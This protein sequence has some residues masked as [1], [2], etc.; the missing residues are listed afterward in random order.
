MNQT[1]YFLKVETILTYTLLALVLCPKMAFAQAKN[2]PQK[3]QPNSNNEW[4]K[5]PDVGQKFMQGCIGSQALPVR[6][7]TIRQS[8]CQCAL[9]SYQVRYTPQIFSQ[10]NAYVT[11]IGN[12]S[13]R[14]VSLMMTPELSQCAE[15]TGYKALNP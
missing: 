5:F 6:Q 4:G 8:Y 14:L 7:K 2:L 13:P 11:K 12:D 3:I 1:Q 15:Q 10:I 9:R